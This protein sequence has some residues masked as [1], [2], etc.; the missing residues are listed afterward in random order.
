MGWFKKSLRYVLVGFVLTYFIIATGLLVVRYVLLPQLNDWRPSLEAQLSQTLGAQV[1]IKDL[2]GQWRGLNPSAKVEG[3]SIT[4]PGQPTVDIP[5]VSAVLSWKTLFLLRPTFLDLYVEG[6]TLNVRQAPNGDL[7]FQGLNIAQIATQTAASSEASATPQTEH[8]VDPHL[9]IDQFLQSPTWLWLKQQGQISIVHSTVI[10]QDQKRQAPDLVLNDLNINLQNTLLSH[11]LSIKVTPPAALSQPIEVGIKK[12]RLL[13]Q[14]GSALPGGSDGEIFISASNIDLQAWKPWVDAPTLAGQFAVRAWLDLQANRV[15]YVT[16]DFAGLGVSSIRKLGDDPALLG[17]SIGQFEMRTEGGGASLSAGIPVPDVVSKDFD[18]KKIIVKLKSND[19]QL[20]FPAKEQTPTVIQSVDLDLSITRESVDNISIDIIQSRFQ[21]PDGL[22]SLLGNWRTSNH[23][24]HGIADLTGQINNLSLPALYRYIPPSI[25]ADTYAWLSHA[26]KSGVI[27]QATFVLKGPLSDYPF[28]KAGDTGQLRLTGQYSG[29]NLDYVPDAPTN[30][31]WPMLKGA[32]GTVNVDQDHLSILANGGQLTATH[33]EKDYEVG[34]QNLRID[35]ES[36]ATKAN[37]SVVTQT[38]GVAA[39]YL[40]LIKYS[41]LSAFTPPEVS[42]ISADGLWE[43][44]FT[45]NLL[46]D[47]PENVSIDANLLFK[48]N[49]IQYDNTTLVKQLT[50]QVNFTQN[51]FKTNNLAGILLGGPVSVKGDLSSESR[52]LVIKGDMSI[53]ALSE[54]ADSPLMSLLKG[55]FAYEAK[56]EELASKQ[57][58]ATFET[59]LKGVSIN[60][61]A[62]LGKTTNAQLPLSLQWVFDEKNKSSLGN[63]DLKIGTLIKAWAVLNAASAPNSTPIL[64][65]FSV[66]VGREP[67]KTAKGFSMAAQL[68]QVDIMRWQ[69]ALALIKKEIDRPVTGRP[70]MPDVSTVRLSTPLVEL[71]DQDY[72]NVSMA[73]TQ[74]TP[75]NWTIDLGAETFSGSI[76]LQTQAGQVKGPINIHFPKLEVGGHDVNADD[77]LKPAAVLGNTKNEND[78]LD[79]VFWRQIEAINVRIDNFVLFGNHVGSLNLNAEPQLEE[80]R[81]KINDLNI[82]TPH[83]ELKSQGFLRV[84]GNRGVDLGIKADVKNLGKLLT[85]VGYPDR[86]LNGSGV[87]EAKIDWAEFPWSTDP[88][89][90]SGSAQVNLKSGVFEHINSRSARLLELLSLQ[91]LKRFFSL[92][93]NADN[94]FKSGFPWGSIEGDFVIESGIVNTK[95]LVIE[96]PVA[97]IVLVGDTNMVRQD[98]NI[99]ALVKPQ[100]DFSGTAIASGFVLNPIVGLTALIGQYIL[101]NPIEKAMQA[102]YNVTGPWD[103]PKVDSKGLSET[104]ADTARV[105]TEAADP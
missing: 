89:G 67:D 85:Y 90:L 14:I 47:K 77:D 92:D 52:R 56:L 10:W 19:L 86:I 13:G 36:M 82:N 30:A 59:S 44:P 6:L 84:E 94:T 16:L 8:T 40:N 38:F 17:W 21:T 41:A 50:G 65:Q 12:G 79:N 102:T 83:G 45:I 35:V 60:L 9:N 26:F 5:K 71:N 69:V 33:A 97:E 98:W 1:Q 46:L 104:N 11:Q 96:S 39:N 31:K 70:L 99:Q 78:I 87:M 22:V 29:L 2:E 105:G 3:L 55:Q 88:V 18:S 62:P 24:A 48:Q 103:D 63:I 80:R 100:L 75:S 32:R 34:V 101:K 91:S 58:K 42:K 7:I 54:V 93:I 66:G 25:D 61:P 81:W 76:R 28:S 53:A 68:S 20:T 37:V 43:L 51:G 23:S 72:K 74:S 49:T 95:N 4:L 15:K 57:L 73:L 64:N 27:D